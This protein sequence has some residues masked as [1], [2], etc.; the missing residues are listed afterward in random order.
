MDMFAFRG[1]WASGHGDDTRGSR[2]DGWI[3]AG[4][5]LCMKE[6]VKSSSRNL[7]KH[8]QGSR[9]SAYVLKGRGVQGCLHR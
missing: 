9:L 6:A 7:L 2:T 5:L 3:I 8:A 4:G 1:S